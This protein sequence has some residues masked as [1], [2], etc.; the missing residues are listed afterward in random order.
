MKTLVRDTDSC[1]RDPDTMLPQFHLLHRMHRHE[2]FSVRLAPYQIFAV[3]GVDVFKETGPCC[4][5]ALSILHFE[6]L[7][8][9]SPYQ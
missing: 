8:S 1:Q 4:R 9:G 5:V 2:R 3:Y 7:V 6:T